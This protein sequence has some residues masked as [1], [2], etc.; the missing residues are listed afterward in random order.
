MLFNTFARR[1][2]DVRALANGFPFSGAEPSSEN[3]TPGCTFSAQS[4]QSFL[5]AA[6]GSNPYS[7]EILSRK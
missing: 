5:L 2:A 7:S 3:P 6:P 1:G 4:T